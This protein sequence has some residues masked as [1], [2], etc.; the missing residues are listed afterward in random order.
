MGDQV[1]LLWQY[2]EPARPLK[3]LEYQKLGPFQ[4]ICQVNL[5]AFHLAL[6]TSMKIHL[7]FHVS[8]LERYYVSTIPGRTLPPPSLIKVNNELKYKVEK[9]LNSR[10][11]KKQLEYLVHW[12]GY[13][14]TKRTWEPAIHLVNAPKKVA[15]F[16]Q[17][18]PHKPK[19]TPY[20]TCR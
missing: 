18:Y 11:N 12:K 5:V 15:I 13:D 14:F 10:F 1:W 8:L 19:A 20:R 9:V 16:H 17:K 2:I 4:I 3:K 6:P 7:V